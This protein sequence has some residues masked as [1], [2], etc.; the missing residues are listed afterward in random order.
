MDRCHQ[1]LV[2]LAAAFALSS[3]TVRAADEYQIDGSHTYPLF[4]I[5]H[6]GLSTLHGRFDNTSGSFVLDREGNKSRVEAVIRV[7]SLNSGH[8]GRDKILLSD[9]FFDAARFPEMRYASSKVSLN[10]ATT[11][12]VEG[13]LSLHGVTRPVKLDVQ[14]LACAIHPLFRVWACGFDAYAT[15]KRSDFGMTAYLPNLVGDEV[16][17]EIAVE[18][19]RVD[20]PKPGGR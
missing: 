14:H 11:A 13:E 1:K 18:A 15:I 16:T 8:A 6:A 9:K 17:I 4:A 3:G 2:F 20:A 19:R 7:D 12:S 10:S 5:N